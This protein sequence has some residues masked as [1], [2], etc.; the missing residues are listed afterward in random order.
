VA[1]SL[2]V[3]SVNGWMNHPRGFELRDGQ[4]V[5]ADPWSALFANSYFWHEFVHMYFAGYI[6]GGFL[7]A[8]PHA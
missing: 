6:V 2:F 7:V 5:G 8:A 4:V 3:I 1:G